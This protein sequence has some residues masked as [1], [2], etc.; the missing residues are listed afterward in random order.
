MNRRLLLVD[1]NNL[2]ARG[3]HAMSELA[4]SKGE[5]TGAIYG[6]IKGMSWCRYQTKTPL[7]QTVVLWDGGHAD[8]RKKIYKAY[9]QGRK[10]N[11]DKEK[12]AD[13]HRQLD[14]I[15]WL[16]SYTGCKQVYVP[17]V[18]ADDLISI[19]VG[20][21]R[22]QGDSAVI[23][24]GDGDFHQLYGQGVLI[25]DPKKEILGIPDIQKKWNVALNKIVLKKAIMGDASDNIKGV[26]KIGDKRAGLC[27]AYLGLRHDNPTTVTPRH[28]WRVITEKNGWSEKDGQ[29]IELAL[30][31]KKVINRNIELMRLPLS[32]EESYYDDD[33]ALDAMEQWLEKPKKNRRKFIELLGRYELDSILENL[34]SW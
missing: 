34:A 24:S 22:K 6:F 4:T 1:G 7:F 30:S 18:E 2:A 8:Y 13:Y 27:C 20:F 9:K 15:R 19:F 28:C 10:L 5:G 33:Q 11:E 26:A 12:R 3:F 21:L 29:W 32:W 14:A 25:F 17:G 16:L 23:Y 31:N